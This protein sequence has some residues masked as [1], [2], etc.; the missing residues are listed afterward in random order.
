MKILPLEC[1]NED[2][3]VL[4]LMTE[5]ARILSEK[6]YIPVKNRTTMTVNGRDIGVQVDVKR[7]NT[8]NGVRRVIT[9]LIGYRVKQTRPYSRGEYEKPVRLA[10]PPSGLDPE[11]I[12]EKIIDYYCKNDEYFTKKEDKLKRANEISSLD[13]KYKEFGIRVKTLEYHDGSPAQITLPAGLTTEQL[14]SVLESIELEL[15]VYA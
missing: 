12:A 8:K 6:G 1:P 4:Q 5:T 15:T 14:D 3:R 7:W 2:L 9:F 11:V 10:E 13:K